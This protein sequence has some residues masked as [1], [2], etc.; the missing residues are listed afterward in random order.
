M[1]K[2]RNVPCQVRFKYPDGSK[3]KPRVRKGKVIKATNVQI[4]EGKRGDYATRI[5][6][7]Q[8]D[9]E[10]KKHIRFAYWRRKEGKKGD[11][12]WNWA[13]QTT[14]VFPVDVTREAI[15]EAKKKGLFG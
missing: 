1:A 7:I 10:E 6:L 12:D 14:W 9:D 8:F 2:I 5:E 15:E 11:S 13:S 3:K 4:H